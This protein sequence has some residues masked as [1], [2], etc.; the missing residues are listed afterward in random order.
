MQP[1]CLPYSTEHKV[2]LTHQKRERP[3]RTK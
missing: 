3:K 1:F 2:T